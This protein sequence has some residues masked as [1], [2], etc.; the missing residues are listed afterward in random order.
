MSISIK[1]FAR[2]WFQMETQ[3]RIILIDPAY[4]KTYLADYEKRTGALLERLE[5]ADLMLVTHA[6]VDHCR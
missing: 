2:A 3:D 5:I 1:W 6:H 4:A